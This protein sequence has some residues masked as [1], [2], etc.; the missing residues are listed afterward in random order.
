MHVMGV[1]PH[2][3]SCGVSQSEGKQW[4]R[5]RADGGQSWDGG[6]VKDQCRAVSCDA[7]VLPSMLSETTAQ[8]SSPLATRATSCASSSAAHGPLRNPGVKTFDHRC[9]H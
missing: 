1:I 5:A 8:F 7:Y 2:A 6:G 4:A 3:S 9:K